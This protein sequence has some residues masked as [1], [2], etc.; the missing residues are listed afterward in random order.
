M[1]RIFRLRQKELDFIDTAF[2]TAGP[3]RQLPTPTQVRALSK[4]VD[5]RPQPTP[6]KYEELGLIVKFGPYVTT[7]EAL[8]LWMIKKVFGDDIPVSEVFGWRV[9]SHGYTFIY[10]E[11]IRESTLEEFW[12]SLG[13]IE[14]RAI[15]DQLSQIT[16]KLRRLEQDP[17]ERFIGS[18]NHEHLPDYVFVYQPKTGPFSSVKDFNDWFAALHQLRLGV[19]YDDPNRPFLPDTGEIN[20]T[21]GDLHRR[22]IIVPS[23][24]PARVVIVDWQQSGWYPDYWEYCKALYTCW[25]EDEWRK[26]YIDRFLQPQTDVFLI[27]SEYTIAMGAV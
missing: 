2:F 22:N 6:V 7:V 3:D 8:N 23:T 26:D 21:H 18:I 4:D 20:L 15:G 9:D 11:L 16:G 19:K 17:S 24:S 1:D 10:M 13:I 5:T 14:K 27:F 12:D 25:Y